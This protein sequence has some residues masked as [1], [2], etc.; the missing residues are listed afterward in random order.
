MCAIRA[1]CTSTSFHQSSFLQEEIHTRPIQIKKPARSNARTRFF[2][3]GRHSDHMPGSRSDLLRRGPFSVHKI[4]T[5]ASTKN[6]RANPICQPL[7]QIQPTL[8]VASPFSIQLWYISSTGLASVVSQ[9]SLP[10]FLLSTKPAKKRCLLAAC[11][12]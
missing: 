8:H 11:L 3:S 7:K 12:F 9:R 5:H 2:Y 1:G 10:R 6:F 4:A